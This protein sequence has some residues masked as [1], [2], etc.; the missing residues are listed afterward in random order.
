MYKL[1]HLREIVL[2]LD[3][4]D[5]N[6]ITNANDELVFRLA[7]FAPRCS[8]LEIS[9]AS[10]TVGKQTAAVLPR[11]LTA[12][13]GGVVDLCFT[14]AEIADDEPTPIY[15]YNTFLS[16]QHFASRLLREP[17]EQDSFGVW[18]TAHTLHLRLPCPLR[19]DRP[20]VLA[21]LVRCCRSGTKSM[22][23]SVEVPA[24]SA[25]MLRRLAESL[26]I[27]RPVDRD[28]RERD[29]DSAEDD[30]VPPPCKRRNRGHRRWQPE[31]VATRI[32]YSLTVIT[33]GGWD[34]CLL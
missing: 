16:P 8:R 1:Q 25:R 6:D 26:G 12:A 9:Y 24:G 21:G 7:G 17:P 3:L 30:V 27:G 18:R 29:G 33:G 4:C 19:T 15:G 20:D 2:D 23:F 10:L 11:L 5:H 32:A 31:T 13:A 34:I 14:R 28:N 22:R